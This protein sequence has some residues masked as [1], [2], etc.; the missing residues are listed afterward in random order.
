MDLLVR[1]LA[2]TG[3]RISEALALTWADIDL[4][5]RR[6]KIE[7][8]IYRGKVGPTKTSYGRREIRISPRWRK[9]SGWLVA[10]LPE[11]AADYCAGVL[12]A[13]RRGS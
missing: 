11:L 8:R 10:G 4:G 9:C 13:E 2:Y 6:I 1:L 12:G 7:R 3:T 5:R